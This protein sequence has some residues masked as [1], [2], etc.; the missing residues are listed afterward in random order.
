MSALHVV[1]LC[2][3]AFSRNT[4]SFISSQPWIINTFSK[5]QVTNAHWLAT[6]SPVFVDLSSTTVS[7][8]LASSIAPPPP[9]GP[10]VVPRL[11]VLVISLL[12][13]KFVKRSHLSLIAITSLLFSRWLPMAVPRP[14]PL[15]RRCNHVDTRQGKR[16][17]PVVTLS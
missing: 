11:C 14:K 16:W 15:S 1:A 6:S 8:C 10:E 4:D 17:A 5:A 3:V 2:L 13:K 12:A 9:L 7:F